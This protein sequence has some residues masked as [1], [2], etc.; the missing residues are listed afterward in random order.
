MQNA[1]NHMYLYES[2]CCSY[3]P[4]NKENFH[5]FI[6]GLAKNTFTICKSDSFRRM[7]PKCRKNFSDKQHSRGIVRLYYKMIGNMMTI[8]YLSNLKYFENEYTTGEQ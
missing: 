7:I 3:H 1:P 5:I 2:V 4:S 8:M 6:K